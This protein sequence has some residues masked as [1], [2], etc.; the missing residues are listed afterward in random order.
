[1]CWR[2]VL[3]L[4]LSEGQKENKNEKGGMKSENV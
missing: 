3:I 4:A 2:L 1:M